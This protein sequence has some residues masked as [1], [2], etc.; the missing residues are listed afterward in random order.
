MELI[1]RTH[2]WRI[3]HTN[4]ALLIKIVKLIRINANSTFDEQ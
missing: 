4:G 1:I 3:P 2:E